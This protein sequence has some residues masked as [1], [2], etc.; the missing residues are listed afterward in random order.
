MSRSWIAAPKGLHM[1]MAFD[2]YCQTAFQ[3]AI[4][5][6]IPTNSAWMLCVSSNSGQLLLFFQYDK[7]KSI[8]ACVSCFNLGCIFISSMILEI[9]LVL[10]RFV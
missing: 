6:Y 8:C 4:L 5:I 10:K 9:K 3:E 7:F 2:V 1:F